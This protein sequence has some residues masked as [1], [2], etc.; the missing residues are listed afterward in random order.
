M[1]PD[2]TDASSKFYGVGKGR[3]YE[4]EGSFHDPLFPKATPRLVPRPHII[5]TL[6]SEM[7][8]TSQIGLE[9]RTVIGNNLPYYLV[10]VDVGMNWHRA[11]ACSHAHFIIK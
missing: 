3:M 1:K 10:R 2:Y 4:R 11:R 8:A 9:A 7:E 5:V 6:R